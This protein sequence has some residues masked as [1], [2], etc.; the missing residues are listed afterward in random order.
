[1]KKLNCIFEKK[2]ISLGFKIWKV[3]WIESD[4]GN[5]HSIVAITNKNFEVHQFTRQA[6]IQ[7]LLYDRVFFYI[8]HSFIHSFIHNDA[9]D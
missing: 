8:L 6:G 3:N 4:D 2:K 5:G 7:L 9:N 1:M